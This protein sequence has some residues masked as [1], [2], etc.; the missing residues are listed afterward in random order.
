MGFGVALGSHREKPRMDLFYFMLGY[1][2]FKG[3]VFGVN[4]ISLLLRIARMWRKRWDGHLV[5]ILNHIYHD[6]HSGSQDHRQANK[7]AWALRAQ[8][9]IENLWDDSIPPSCQPARVSTGC[10]SKLKS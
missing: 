8:W 9:A 10:G 1:G 4:G 5:K 6:A 2:C 3:T 7:N